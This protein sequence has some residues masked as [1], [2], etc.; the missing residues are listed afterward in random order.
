MQLQQLTAPLVAIWLL[1]LVL[2]GVLGTFGIPGWALLSM[3][4]AVPLIVVWQIG[5]GPAPTL[6]ESIRAARR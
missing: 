3:L 6:S 2:A 5:R 4:A 1:A